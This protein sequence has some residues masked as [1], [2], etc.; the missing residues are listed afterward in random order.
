[1][2]LQTSNQHGHHQPHQQLLHAVGALLNPATLA[3]VRQRIE[4]AA[5]AF[6]QV[7]HL[8]AATAAQ[9][10]LGIE[11]A[12]DVLRDVAREWKQGFA[13][14]RAT[15]LG[16]PPPVDRLDVCL[17]ELIAAAR[18]VVVACEVKHDANAAIPTVWAEIGE[19]H[20][21]WRT[22]ITPRRAGRWPT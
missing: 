14:H 13:W 4:E 5:Q 21:G 9:A 20:K 16:W 10:A 12:L 7:E 8:D 6:I 11:H 15:H 18:N 19:I 3:A 22:T 17:T 1:M 2:T